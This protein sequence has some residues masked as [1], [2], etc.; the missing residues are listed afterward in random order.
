MEIDDPEEQEQIFKTNILLA[1][2]DLALL[3]M[4]D[5]DEAEP[6][7]NNSSSSSSL[8]SSTHSMPMMPSFAERW[9]AAML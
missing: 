8:T 3:D 7:G 6:E 2:G 4:E 9:K 1:L 5:E